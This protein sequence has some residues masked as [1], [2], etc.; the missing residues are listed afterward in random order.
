MNKEIKTTEDVK[1][2]VQY[3]I[4]NDQLYHFDDEPNDIINRDN[5]AVFTVEEC[6]LINQRIEEIYAID[7]IEVAF[8]YANKYLE[9]YEQE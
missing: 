9:D 2:F 4:D 5:E 1:A 8:D 6:N 3:L 7:A